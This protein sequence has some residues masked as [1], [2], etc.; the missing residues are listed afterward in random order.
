M[1]YML[2]LNDT[3]K[4][5]L[6]L[7]IKAELDAY[8][9]Y[10]SNF[11]HQLRTNH[12]GFLELIRKLRLFGEATEHNISLRNIDPLNIPDVFDNNLFDVVHFS[13]AAL[14]IL[15]IAVL[16]TII[17]PRVKRNLGVQMFKYY[18]EQVRCFDPRGIMISPTT[19]LPELD[20]YEKRHIQLHRKAVRIRV[21]YDKNIS[22]ITTPYL[23]K[24]FG[25]VGNIQKK[26]WSIL[27]I[28]QKPHVR[29]N[30]NTPWCI[31]LQDTG[32]DYMLDYIDG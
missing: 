32:K 12:E 30:V 31:N 18:S 9:H 6:S 3:Q 24:E 11:I 20:I 1:Q 22:Y 7:Y 25:V 23:P 10:N 15:D 4:K 8:N 17:S 28:H 27:I 13:D 19:Y 5:I 26:Q 16:D 29:I 2:A 21:D 14:K